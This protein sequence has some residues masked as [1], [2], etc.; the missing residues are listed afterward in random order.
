MTSARRWRQHRANHVK[1]K[2]RVLSLSGHARFTC[3]DAGVAAAP[4]RLSRQIQL[5]RYSNGVSG[6]EAT[7]FFCPLTVR[8]SSRRDVS[9]QPSTPTVLI[10]MFHELSLDQ[11]RAAVES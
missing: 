1:G 9:P 11:G 2:P 5:K 3:Q 7:C 8:A 10:D 4:A 6:A